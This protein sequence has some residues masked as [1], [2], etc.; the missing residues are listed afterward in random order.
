METVT[1]NQEYFDKLYDHL[2][3]EAYNHHPVTTSGVAHVVF[4]KDTPREQLAENVKSLM[5]DNGYAV[6]SLS[7]STCPDKLK[8]WQIGLFG[9][10]MPDVGKNKVEVSTIAPEANGK[11]FA[12]STYAQPMHTDEGHTSRFPRVATLFCAQ[13]SSEGGVSILVPFQRAYDALVD[14]F[15]AATEALFDDKAI[16]VS[17]IYG[18]ESKSVLLRLPEGRVGITYSS[19][20]QQLT[21]SPLVLDMFN[22]ITNFVHQPENQIRFKLNAGDLLMMDN[23]R[24]L[25]ARTK[26]KEGDARTLYRMWFPRLSAE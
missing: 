21:C 23:C 1:L 14:K 9:P 2:N 26:F 25:H 13:Q 19:I 15:G 24:M 20:V 12:N 17:N 22:F 16:T 10:V 6:V 3:E 11:Y 8:A 7:A 18:T 4:D 5:F